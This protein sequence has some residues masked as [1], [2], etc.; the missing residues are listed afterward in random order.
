MM[1][2]GAS[3]QQIMLRTAVDKDQ[4]MNWEEEAVDEFFKTLKVKE[5]S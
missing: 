2:T 4:Y 5:I 3:W 1:A